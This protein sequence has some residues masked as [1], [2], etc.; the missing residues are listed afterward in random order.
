MK[1]QRYWFPV[2]DASTGWGW[3]LPVVWQGWVAYVVFFAAL[4][5]GIVLLVPYGQMVVIAIQLRCGRAFPGRGGLEGRTAEQ[6]RTVGW[7]CCLL[8]YRCTPVTIDISTNPARHACS[9]SCSISSIVMPVS[10]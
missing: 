8:R 6:T 7:G 4:I 1:A 10:W 2:R 9:R 3:G 5:G